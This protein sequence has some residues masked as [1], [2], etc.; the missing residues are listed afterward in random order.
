MTDLERLEGKDES[1]RARLRALSDRLDA[2]E[3]HRA[4]PWER[5][6][7]WWAGIAGVSFLFGI[8]VGATVI[9]EQQVNHAAWDMQVK[10]NERQG[11]INRLQFNKIAT[12]QLK[13]LIEERDEIARRMKEK[14][15]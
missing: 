8:A 15:K 10:L 7:K 9:P 1:I 4:G 3:L 14:T 6:A 11:E 5:A 2:A 13:A 12:S